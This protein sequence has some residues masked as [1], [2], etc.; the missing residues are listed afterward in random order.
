MPHEF[1]QHG[2]RIDW[3][4]KNRFIK[5]K[6]RVVSDMDVDRSYLPLTTHYLLTTYY[7]LLTITTIS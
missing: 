5:D 1:P 6:A 7:L 2:L 3:S 4:F